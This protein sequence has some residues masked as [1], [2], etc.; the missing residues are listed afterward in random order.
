[1]GTL[2]AETIKGL[3]KKHELSQAEL[4]IRSQLS[5]LTISR[6]E[7]GCTPRSTTIDKILNALGVNGSLKERTL[8]LVKKE[9]QGKVV[10]QTIT[11]EDLT[12]LTQELREAIKPFSTLN[13]TD[14]KFTD[15][16]I[17]S[18]LGK[19]VGVE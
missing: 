17:S 5:R 19:Y 18:I 9:A 6:I 2:I 4:A 3:R 12:A 16:L 8:N 10:Y 14:D 1:M 15:Q 13:S 11:K 7:K